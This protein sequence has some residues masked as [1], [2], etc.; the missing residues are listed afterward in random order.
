MKSMVSIVILTYQ[1]KDSILDLLTQMVKLTDPDLEI[2]V[3]DNA[4]TDGTADEV[5]QL[6]PQVKLL[7]LEKNGGTGSRNRGMEVAR[8]EI[9]INLDD[10]VFGISNED[11]DHLRQRF[12]DDP[13]LGG[14]CFKVTWPGTDRVRD[15]VHRQPMSM[16]EECFPTYEITEGAVAYRAA[17]VRDLGFYR[18]D[19]FI[20]HEGLDLSLRLLDAD[21]KLEYDGRIVTEHFHASGGRK[22]WRRY[23]YDTRNTIWI[24]ALHMPLPMAVPYLIIG[25]GAMWV[26]SVRDGFLTTWLRAVKDGLQSVPRLQRER[27]PIRPATRR[28]I[29]EIDSTRANLGSLLIMRLKDRGF[30][31]G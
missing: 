16:A 2:I 19:F 21:W 24:A 10:D 5:R 22:S 23:Y 4:S 1:R 15:W 11:L 8:G 28:I 17:A 12:S 20:S 7:A 27:R 6:F 26:Y 25:L 18:E 9:I 29:K 3:V 14:L 13:R 30:H 31:M